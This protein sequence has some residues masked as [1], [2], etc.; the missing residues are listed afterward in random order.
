MV[1]KS[2]GD[3]ADKRAA[4]IALFEE[5]YVAAALLRSGGNVSKA[6]RD[7]GLNRVYFT[8]L[9]RRYGFRGRDASEAI[10]KEGE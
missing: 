8:R 2:V 1:K 4:A 6:A 9:A 5:D 10:K 7:S 3:Y